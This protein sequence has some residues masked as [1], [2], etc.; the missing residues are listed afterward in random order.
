MLKELT[1]QDLQE[2]NSTSWILNYNLDTKRLPVATRSRVQDRNQLK[3]VGQLYTRCGKRAYNLTK[4]C[5]LIN[6][7]IK[8]LKPVFEEQAKGT[9]REAF[10]KFNTL[11]LADCKN[12]PNYNT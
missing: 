10:N 1:H 8:I 2:R 5:K 6:A 11:C 9:F 4:D 3:G 12:V 7:I